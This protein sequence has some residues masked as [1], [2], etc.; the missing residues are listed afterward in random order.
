MWKAF[1]ELGTIGWLD[2]DHRPRMISCQAAG[3]API[4]T[5]WEAGQRF[6]EPFPNAATAASGL[7]VPAAVGD[8]MILDAVN[9]SGGQARA[10]DEQLLL[11]WARRGAEL[12]G[13]SFAPEAGACLAVLE[14]MVAEG[15]ID[16][17]ERVVVYNTGAAQKYLE[18]INTGLPQ[19]PDPVDWSALAS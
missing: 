9:E 15:A 11:G 14:Q 6:A 5:A 16:P 18:V 7:R 17:N 4:S 8:F 19:L 1:A 2:T 3:C 10:A 12:E 13:I